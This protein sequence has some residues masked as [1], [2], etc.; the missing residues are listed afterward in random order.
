MDGESSYESDI[1]ESWSLI[2]VNLKGEPIIV[3]EACSLENPEKSSTQEIHN[4]DTKFESSSQKVT[5]EINSDCDC[6]GKTKN[7]G[8]NLHCVSTEK[9]LN[10]LCKEDNVEDRNA[11]DEKNVS[12]D[13][14]S[15]EIIDE[16]GIDRGEVKLQVLKF[17]NNFGKFMCRD[18]L[19]L[20]AKLSKFIKYCS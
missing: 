8:T 18:T 7:F 16:E 11:E 15:I 2:D 13:S 10:S 19:V 17:T 3:H 5:K 6:I 14:E 9:E 4:S 20:F 1:S 12:W